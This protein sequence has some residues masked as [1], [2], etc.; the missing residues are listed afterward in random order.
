MASIVR[1]NPSLGAGVVLASTPYN[2]AAVAVRV[3][4]GILPGFVNPH[5]PRLLD[6]SADARAES[7]GFAGE[8]RNAAY[9]VRIAATLGGNPLMTV[10]S[11]NSPE[12]RKGIV[13]DATLAPAEHDLFFSRPPGDP[14]F[15]YVQFV[16]VGGRSFLWNG[17]WA[18]PR[19]PE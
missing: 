13:T 16:T 5:V 6:R 4:G 15:A 14:R 7:R 11:R 17:R 9:H 12:G 8:Y 3:F 2:P 10:W 19:T 1:L 18:I